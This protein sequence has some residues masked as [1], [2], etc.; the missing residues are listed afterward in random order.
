MNPAH[1]EPVTQR[2]NIRRGLVGTHNA[3]KTHCA[4]GHE[5]AGDNLL[6]SGGQRY[7]RECRR[8]SNRKN[9]ALKR[10]GINLEVK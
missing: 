10:I 2:E 4:K 3:S 9:R 7:C 8:L 5:Y 1:L 6:V